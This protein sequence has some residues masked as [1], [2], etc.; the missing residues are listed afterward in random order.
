METKKNEVYKKLV[1]LIM[2]D[3]LPD[4][5]TER[6]VVE[7]L[8]GLRQ[9]CDSIKTVLGVLV[10]GGQ[11]EKEAMLWADEVLSLKQS[12]KW[13]IRL[14]WSL[15]HFVKKFGVHV[16]HTF[17]SVSDFSGLIAGKL[18]GVPVINGSIRNARKKKTLRDRLSRCA[19]QY[20]DWI[21]ANSHAGL[22]AYG[23]N[24]WSNASVVYNGVDFCRFEEIIPYDH[25]RPYICMVGNFTPKKDH[26]ALIE[27]FPLI[28]QEFPHYDLLL[29][30]RGCLEQELRR[31]AAR[32]DLADRISFITDCSAPEI[33]IKNSAAC[34]L[35]SP[36]G[37]GLSNVLI[38]YGALSRP[39]VATDLGGNREII[40]HGIT[41]ILLQSHT[42]K[43][44][45]Q[46]ICS[47]LAD[48]KK[49]EELGQKA[50]EHI[51]N[52]F[53]LGEMISKYFKLY[54]SLQ[55]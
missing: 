8:K 25:Q 33:Y 26:K 27:A 9:E 37:E 23:V 54:N 42:K 32:L 21:V 53:S 28:L 12:H 51:E 55:S 17:G 50:R 15:F 36:D 10:K 18:A 31:V 16:V 29:V 34:V 47:I 41:G 49:A 1:V 3:A 11:R 44:I 39:T 46:A 20:A 22:L 52:H 6:Q 5:G 14:A 30:G 19:M 45:S 38:E 4:G 2:V 48:K 40:K 43:E 7:L 35:L 24:E 13:D